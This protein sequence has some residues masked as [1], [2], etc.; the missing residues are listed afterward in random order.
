MLKLYDLAIAREWDQAMAMQ[1]VIVRL[2]AEAGPLLA[3]WDIDGIDPVFD[4][5]LAVAS[6]YLVGHQRTRPPYIGWSDTGLAQFR[7][8]LKERFPEFASV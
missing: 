2:R 5:G 7:V 3:Q 8:W 4:K 6:G 1:S